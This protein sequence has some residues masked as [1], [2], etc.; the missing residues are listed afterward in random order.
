V[1]RRVDVAEVELVGRDLAV[2][3][4]VPLAQEEQELPLGEGGVDE[5]AKGI[6]W[7]ARSQAA[8]QGYSHLSGIETTSRLNSCGPVAV[9]TLGGAVRAAAAGPDRR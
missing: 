7:K 4:H 5:R 6:M 9:A 1:H 2:G 8:Y 3:M